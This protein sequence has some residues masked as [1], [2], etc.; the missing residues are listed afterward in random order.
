MLTQLSQ[1]T[2]AINCLCQNGSAP[3][4]QYY[5]ETMPTV[6]RPGGIANHPV[7][8]SYEKPPL[9]AVL[10]GANMSIPT[11]FI[12]NE[13]F[14]ECIDSHTGDATAQSNCTKSI[15]DQCGTLDPNKANVGGS[16]T[17]SSSGTPSSSG[18]AGS[19]T[20][21]SAHAAAPTNMQAYG[22]GAALAAM[23]LFAYLL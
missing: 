12:C 13:A 10:L 8:G 21:T 3:G 18:K 17:A 9:A 6:S 11:Q 14:K 19:P 23:G 20:T 22:S 1:N 7:T 4:L 5:L 15:H 16:S 2:L